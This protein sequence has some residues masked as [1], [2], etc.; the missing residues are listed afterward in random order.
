MYVLIPLIGLIAVG[1]L[2][3]YIYILMEGDKK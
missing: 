2:V 3:Y 1:L